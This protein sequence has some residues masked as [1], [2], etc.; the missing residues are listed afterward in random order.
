MNNK[1]VSV[2][3]ITYNSAETVL[4]TLNSIKNQTYSPIELII[5]DDNST[6]NTVNLVNEWLDSN[7]DIFV[8]TKVITSEKNTGVT[9]N[10]NRAC[11]AANG[12]YIKDIAGDDS[13]L[14]EYIKKCID[15]FETNPKTEILFTKVK[16]IDKN[17][18]EVIRNDVNYK[19]FELSAQEQFEYIINFGVPSI[20]TPSVIYKKSTLEKLE[21]FDGR[22]PMWEDGPFYFKATKNGIKLHLN[23]FIGVNNG[24]FQGSI[25]HL[26]SPRHKRSIA[27]FYF[28]YLKK[29]EKS[30]FTRIKNNIKFSLFYFSN[31]RCID[32]FINS[33]ISRK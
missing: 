9:A 11:K 26:M 32:A 30:I 6:D 28:Y 5:S 22:I 2:C 27:L 17:G 29:H 24:V 12:Y 8:N 13:L 16:F 4:D 21:W 18:K 19:Y 23:D 31:I 33:H 20:P 14:P 7:S 15:Y 25:S 10:V 1:L 3:V